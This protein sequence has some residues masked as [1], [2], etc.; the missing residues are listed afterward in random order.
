MKKPTKPFKTKSYRVKSG[1]VARI[2][3]ETYTKD[4]FAISRKIKVRD[5]HTCQGKGCGCKVR[6]ELN[7][8]HIVSLSRGGTNSP[9]NLITLCENCHRKRHRHL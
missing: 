5:N 9:F 6:S 3:R 1:T 7:V 8:H 4:W 2:Q